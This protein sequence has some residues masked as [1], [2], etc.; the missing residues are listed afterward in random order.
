MRTGFG[1]EWLGLAGME[2]AGRGTSGALKVFPA[3]PRPAK[4]GALFQAAAG[5]GCGVAIGPS[6]PFTALEY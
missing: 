3:T 4:L 1:G 2:M 6:G 5:N